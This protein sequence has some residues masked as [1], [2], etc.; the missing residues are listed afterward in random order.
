MSPAIHR[1]LCTSAVD[2]AVPGIFFATIG[3]LH[4]SLIELDESVRSGIP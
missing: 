4:E 1:R 2:K 3:L